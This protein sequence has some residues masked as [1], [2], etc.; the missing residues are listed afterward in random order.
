[1][2]TEIQNLRNEAV[3]LQRMANDI[4]PEEGDKDDSQGPN[5]DSGEAPS[6]ISKELI[7]VAKEIGQK[8]KKNK[9]LAP[10]KLNPQQERFCILYTSPEFLGNGLQAYAEAYDIDLATRGKYA[11]AK[12]AA[13]NLLTQKKILD[14]INAL[15]EKQGFTDTFVDGQLNFI[16]NQNADLKSK[17]RGISEYNKL[18]GRIIDRSVNLHGTLAEALK[19]AYNPQEDDSTEEE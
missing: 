17:V 11:M 3:A 8:N 15:L 14:R 10:Q 18:K 6:G 9:S 1:M 16:I 2:N 13:W 5:I 12:S 4:L 19:T 7:K